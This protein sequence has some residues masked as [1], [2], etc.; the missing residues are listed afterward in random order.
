MIGLHLTHTL[1][2]ALT[3]VE[4]GKSGDQHLANP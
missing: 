4:A 2:Y 1:T 3:G